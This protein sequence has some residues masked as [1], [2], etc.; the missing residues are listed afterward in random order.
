MT[1]HNIGKKIDKLASDAQRGRDPY[2]L[3][4]S[5]KLPTFVV[6]KPAYKPK[7][8]VCEP[9]KDTR[10]LPSDDWEPFFSAHWPGVDAFTGR[11]WSKR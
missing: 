6:D 5:G 4:G 3:P 9:F 10:Y 11:G 8:T 2:K 7:I 1:L